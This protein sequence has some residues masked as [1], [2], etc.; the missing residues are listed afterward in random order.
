MYF[1]RRNGLPYSKDVVFQT[2]TASSMVV[3]RGEG[4][5]VMT[6]VKGVKCAVTEGVQTPGCPHAMRCAD[7]VLLKSCIP[8]TYTLLLNNVTPI[9]FIY[10]V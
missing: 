10:N 9:T 5:E 2:Q 4:N 7:G 3:A 6:R 8:G 1:L